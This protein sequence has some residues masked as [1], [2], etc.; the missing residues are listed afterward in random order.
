M[1]CWRTLCI[2]WIKGV[3]LLCGGW[4][5]ERAESIDIVPNRIPLKAGLPSGYIPPAPLPPLLLRSPYRTL[6]FP[7]SGGPSLLCSALLACSLS[8]TPP[9]NESHTSAKRPQTSLIAGRCNS[10]TC[11]ATVREVT[12]S[13]FAANG[14]SEG[15][16]RGGDRR[17]QDEPS[18]QTEPQFMTIKEGQR[19]VRAL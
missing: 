14:R 7:S 1:S 15:R 9:P 17:T 8:E 10:I 2:L 18:Q 6:P 4:M 5:C 12:Y 19:N 11:K 3:C 13:N 16:E